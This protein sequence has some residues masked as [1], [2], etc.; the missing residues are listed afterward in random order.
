TSS[1]TR[2]PMRI[3]P[4][5]TGSRATSRHTRRI[6][7]SGSAPRRRSRLAPPTA[8]SRGTDVRLH[9]P[10]PLRWSDLDAY[11]HVNN[12][13]MLSLLEEARIPAFWV[14]TDT[15]EHRP[16]ASTADTDGTP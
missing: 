9:V 11:G 13:R 14:R 10:T 7:S 16:A 12:A 6:R 5:G 4:T 15:P 1:P 8:S 3:P 2:A